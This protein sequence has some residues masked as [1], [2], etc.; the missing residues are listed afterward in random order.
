VQLRLY[1]REIAGLDLDQEIVAN[2]ID[3]EPVN[4]NFKSIARPRIPLFQ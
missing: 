1:R 3:D 4:R 2:D